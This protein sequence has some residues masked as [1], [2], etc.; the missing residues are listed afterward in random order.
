MF[1]FQSNY[2]FTLILHNFNAQLHSEG[3]SDDTC[4]QSKCMNTCENLETFCGY[5][6]TASGQDK[7]CMLR[8]VIVD[9]TTENDER[10]NPPP[11]STPFTCSSNGQSI[12]SV[13]DETSCLNACIGCQNYNWACTADF[14]TYT[15]TNKAINGTI[16]TT[17]FKCSC[18]Q[19][20]CGSG[21]FTNVCMDSGYNN[22]NGVI[23]VGVS[24]L[25]LMS[26]LLGIASVSWICI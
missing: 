7:L 24:R 13:T 15:H 17:S 10:N 2:L 5:N 9:D 12:T 11:C 14:R 26:V 8:Q 19:P 22:K 6:G 18:E 23:A 4:K 25:L 21:N 1:S 20:N 3:E 16:K